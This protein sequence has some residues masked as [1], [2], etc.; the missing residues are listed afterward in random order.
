MKAILYFKPLLTKPLLYSWL[1]LAACGGRSTEVNSAPENLNRPTENNAGSVA[2]MGLVDREIER[3]D[4]SGI[5]EA[6]NVVVKDQSAWEALW[7]AHKST[8]TPRPP[9]PAVDFST[10]HVVGVFLGNRMNGCYGVKIDRVHQEGGRII[11]RY[12]EKN[13]LL[14]ASVPL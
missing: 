2:T 9:T 4:Y 14:T 1:I 10:H 7:K 11:V 13:L 3:T 12:T 5:E 6:R 8:V